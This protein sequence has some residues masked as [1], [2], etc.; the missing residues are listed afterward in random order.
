MDPLLLNPEFA[1]ADGGDAVDGGGGKRE[2][3]RDEERFR[4]NILLNSDWSDDLSV[5]PVD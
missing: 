3:E 1:A 2:V 4:M 5:V